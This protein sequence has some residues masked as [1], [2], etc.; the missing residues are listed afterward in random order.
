VIFRLRAILAI[1]ALSLIITGCAPAVQPAAQP[2]QPT[3]PAN[4]AP[5]SG[6]VL[7]RAMTSEPAAIDPQGAPSSGLSLVLPYL[8]DTLV[9]RD[10]DNRLLPLLAEK[11]EVAADGKTITMTLRSGV[12]F[13]DGS[14]LT[15][16]AVRLTFERFKE[17]GAK[18]PIYGG[19]QQIGGI[20][21]VDEL[22]VRFTFEQPAANFWSTISMPYA[23]ILSPASIQ[24]A[25][26]NDKARLIGTGPF[27]LGE[28][29]AGQSITLLR[30]AAYAWGPEMF[31]NRGAPHL[32]KTVF[33]VIPDAAT[34]LAA[35]QAGEVDVIF[36]NNPDHLSKL[37][38]DPNIQLQEAVLN[39]LI[40]LGFN[41]QKA[42]F[43]DPQVRRALAHAVNKAEILEL[44]LGGVGIQAFAPLPPTLP[45]FAPALAQ[46]ELGYDPAKA[47]ALLSEAGFTR[48][49]DGAW[50]KGGQPLK[51]VLLTS[52]RAPNDAIAALLQSQLKAIGVPAEI[53]QLDSKAVM[54]ATAAGKFDLLLWRYDWN[55]PDAL[56]IY[57]GSDR[58]GS[59]NRVAYSNE[60]VDDLL[61]L[62]AHEMD[63]AKRQQIYVEAQKLIL[64]DA[65]WQPLYVP[66]DVLAMGAQVQ[67]ARVGYMGRLL[68]NDA[69]VT[70]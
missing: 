15:A 23:A 8:F 29:Q 6:G 2:A 49:S 9:V 34:Q 43:D 19:I 65:P 40:Y 70:R 54:E 42:P 33:K 66:L 64:A 18:S 25:A 50:T 46:H 38:Q 57:L 4:P 51:A 28:W 59:T 22:T 60:A 52:N 17:K 5:V 45:G 55:D 27:T 63:E 41:T 48:G 47:Q 61:T 31:E 16:D 13:H 14:P 68:L 30:N 10:S 35:L 1:I 32:E 62:G 56:N 21:A 3:A 53:Q 20:E 12:T 36:V 7:V 39:S 24:Q 69:R 26:T 67:G 11:W 58:I 44:A 37:R